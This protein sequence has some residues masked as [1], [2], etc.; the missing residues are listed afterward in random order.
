[1]AKGYGLRLD[2]LSLY[3]SE[4]GEVGGGGAGGSSEIIYSFLSIRK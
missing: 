4:T 1:M 2:M 3:G